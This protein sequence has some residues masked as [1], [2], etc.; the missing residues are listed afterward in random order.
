MLCGVSARPQPPE[1]LPG[2]T[3]DDAF[4]SDCLARVVLDHVTSRWGVLVLT[5]LAAG[6]LRFHEL[7]TKIEGIS[8]KMLSQTLRTLVRDGLVERTVEPSSPPRV[9]YSLTPLGEGLTRPL[10]QLF[11][12]IRDHAQLVSAAQDRHDTRSDGQSD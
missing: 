9:S 8:E 7:R 5:G 3:A 12:W 6:P 4:R 10:Q 2:G 11:V 1:S